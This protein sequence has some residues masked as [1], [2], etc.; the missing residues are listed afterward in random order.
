MLHSLWLSEQL[1]SHSKSYSWRPLRHEPS[2]LLCWYLHAN[3]VCCCSSLITPTSSSCGLSKML[4][5]K[6]WRITSCASGMLMVYTSCLLS[7]CSCL[8]PILIVEPFP[9]SVSEWTLFLSN[10]TSVYTAWILDDNVGPS[11]QFVGPNG[12]IDSVLHWSP[13]KTLVYGKIMMVIMVNIVPP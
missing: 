2:L 1:T 3:T 6:T 8:F 4:H 10:Y 11:A 7:G 13:V 5:N 12:N 9:T